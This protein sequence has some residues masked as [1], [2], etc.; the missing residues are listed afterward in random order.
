M[1]NLNDQF[2]RLIFNLILAVAMYGEETMQ[3]Y[4]YMNGERMVP[5]AIAS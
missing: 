5:Y 2:E 3:N 1:Q 4:A